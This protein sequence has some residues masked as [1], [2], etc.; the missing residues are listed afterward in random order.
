MLNRR[1]H[2]TMRTGG[3]LLK[4]FGLVVL[5]L[6]V[7][8]TWWFL[9]LPDGS[10]FISKNPQQTTMMLH[11]EQQGIRGHHTWV[12]LARMAPQLRHAVIVAEDAN[13]YRHHGIDWEAV[14]DAVQRDWNEHRLYRGGSTITQQLAK[15]LYLDPSKTLSRKI[16]EAVIAMRMERNLSKSRIL[17]LYLNVVEWGRGIY[18][19]EAAAQHYFGK[20]SAD[21]TVE[22]AA[23]LAAIL[24]APLRYE[25]NRHAKAV[26]MRAKT[27]QQFVERR[28]PGRPALP[29]HDEAERLPQ[30]EE[31]PSIEP[32]PEGDAP[33]TDHD[34]REPP[35]PAITSTPESQTP[36]DA[37]PIY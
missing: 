14:R 17:E 2:R 3:R 35:E 32:L 25:V 26:L 33:P 18:G 28:L 6:V 27:I 13:F 5:G 1:R 23:W 16:T 7:V 24:P 37:P 31:P 8:G 21:L 30:E 34:V 9:T 4:W 12:P 10:A 22:E 36:A 19:A 11:R 20:S 15:N 29:A